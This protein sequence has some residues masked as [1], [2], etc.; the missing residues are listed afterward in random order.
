MALLFR[1]ALAVASLSDVEGIEQVML[2]VLWCDFCDR[3]A[4]PAYS[5][6]AFNLGTT[7][8]DSWQTI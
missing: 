3:P 5:T 4:V 1:D 2:G 6:L 7:A 8:V